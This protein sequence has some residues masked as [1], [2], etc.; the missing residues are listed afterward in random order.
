MN[1]L[2]NFRTHIND[3]LSMPGDRQLLVNGSWF[4]VKG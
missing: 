3:E 4:T 1:G 2:I